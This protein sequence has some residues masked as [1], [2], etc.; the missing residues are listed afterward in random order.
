[1]RLRPATPER[2]AGGRG[3]RDRRRPRR[4]RRGRLQPRATSTT[5]G[6]SSASTSRATRWSSRTTRARSIGYAH[7]RGSDVL[8]AVD[9]R[10]EG[11]GVG[12]ALLEWAERRGASA[13]TTQLRQGVGD[14]GASAPRAARGPRLRA[15]RAATGGWSATASRGETADETGLR[16]LDADGR[17]RA[18][19]DH[20]GARSRATPPTSRR[21][22]R[23]LDAARVRR[24]RR[25]TT[26]SRASPSATAA[27]RLRARPPLGGRHA[28][29]PAARRPPRPRRARASAARC[30]KRVFA[31]AGAAGRR[32]VR[33]TSPPTTRTRSRLYERVGHDPALAGRR[34]PEAAARLGRP[35]GAIPINIADHVGRTPMVQF[36]PP[37]ARGRRRGLRQARDVQPRRLGQGPHRRGHDRGGRDR[38]AGSSRAGRRSSR[39]PA[40][41]PASRSRSCARPRATS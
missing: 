29:R 25:S 12:T 33:S 31:A 22:W 5:S 41:T 37:R 35:M 38:R 28:L 21:A 17:A 13:A 30:C 1:M 36:A 27:S 11:E 7:F 10:R 2:R 16:A 23:T 19:R 24:P 3:P 18:A 32:S 4:D 15:R 39:P 26:R 14:R 9:P 40:A 34:L 8:A 20:R 6:A